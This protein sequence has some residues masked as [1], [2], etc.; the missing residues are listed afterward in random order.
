MTE[1]KKD[2]LIKTDSIEEFK[3]IEEAY[4]LFKQN[5]KLIQENVSRFLV[6]SSSENRFRICPDG[7][8]GK[9]KEVITF[10]SN[11]EGRIIQSGS[12]NWLIGLRRNT[13]SISETNPDFKVEKK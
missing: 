6:Q 10:D 2:Y 11:L 7:K 12:G 9:I 8:Y 4:N 13:Y 5:Y 3:K 1:E